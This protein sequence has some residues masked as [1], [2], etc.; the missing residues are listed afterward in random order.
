MHTYLVFGHW[1]MEECPVEAMKHQFKAAML[2]VTLHSH[3]FQNYGTHNTSGI[4]LQSVAFPEQMVLNVYD[5]SII[6]NDNCFLNN[7]YPAS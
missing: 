7:Y 2:I 3:L 5:H 1:S 6:M 4:L